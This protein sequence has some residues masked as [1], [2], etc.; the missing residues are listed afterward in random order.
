MH[1]F[2]HSIKWQMLMFPSSML[3]ALC[4][5]PKRSNIL[6]C[7]Q[8]SLSLAG[9][10]DPWGHVIKQYDSSGY[11]SV[12]NFGSLV[13]GINLTTSH[14]MKCSELYGTQSEFSDACPGKEGSLRGAISLRW[15]ITQVLF[16]YL[17]RCGFFP[18]IFSWGWPVPKSDKQKEPLVM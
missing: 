9:K 18:S 12:L 15:Q 14:L 16:G 4:L 2:T 10:I 7:S 17:V 3:N 13:P 11:R 1:L 6:S 8:V 5:P